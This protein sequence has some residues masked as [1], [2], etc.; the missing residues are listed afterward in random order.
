MRHVEALEPEHALAAPGE[1]VERCAPHAA[2]ADDDRVVALGHAGDPTRVVPRHPGRGWLNCRMTTVEELGENRVRLTVEVPPAQVKHAVEHAVS[3]LAESVKLPGFR[4]GK[5]PEPVLI[6]R[7][8]KER[9]YS[10]AVDSHIGGW[11]WS[12]ASRNRVRPIADPQYEFELP[13]SADEPWTF[14]ATVEVQP[15]PEIVDWTTLEVPRA[16]GRGTAGG[17]R[18]RDRDAARGGRRARARRGAPGA[19]RRHGRHRHRRPRGRGA[20]RHRRRARRRAAR[21][22]ARAGAR[23]R[24]AGRHEGGR[25]PAG[26]RRERHGRGDAPRREREDPAAGRRRARP[27]GERVRH[28]RGAARERRVD[29]PRADRRGDRRRVPDGRGGR[30]RQGVEGAAGARHSSRRAPP[31]SSPASSARSS[32]AASRSRPTCRRAARAPRSFSVRW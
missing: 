19:D 13:S 7:L 24:V 10:E 20:A 1:V 21:G 28:A 3:D 9:I 30:A 14:A 8:G 31:T 17:C 29:V 5:I 15:L 22:R 25:V 27:R 2:D 4:K 32:G 12:A 16:G 6:S 26:G 23:R 11:F 18:R